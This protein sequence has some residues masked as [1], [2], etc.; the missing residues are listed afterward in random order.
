MVDIF[1]EVVCDVS[2]LNNDCGQENFWKQLIKTISLF[3]SEA[4]QLSTT[5]SSNI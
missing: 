5:L 2:Y 3:E 4:I 1:L